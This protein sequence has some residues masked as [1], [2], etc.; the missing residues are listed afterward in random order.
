LR[1][2][3]VKIIS[4]IFA[5]QGKFTRIFDSTF[6]SGDFHLACFVTL[7]LR[8]QGAHRPHSMWINERRSNNFSQVLNHSSDIGVNFC[9]LP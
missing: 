2:A 1:I 9:C 5:G 6:T 7:F 8:K 4:S 3:R